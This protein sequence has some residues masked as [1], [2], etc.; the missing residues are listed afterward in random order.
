MSNALPTISAEEFRCICKELNTDVY[1]NKPQTFCEVAARMFTYYGEQLQ[2]PE[3]GAAFYDVIGSDLLLSEILS[4]RFE[5]VLESEQSL[6]DW[7]MKTVVQ[8]LK[9]RPA[10]KEDD[11]AKESISANAGEAEQHQATNDKPSAN[12]TADML[13]RAK[14]PTLA[15]VM[16]RQSAPPPKPKS[17]GGNPLDA[18]LGKREDQP[19]ATETQDP[20]KMRE[21]LKTLVNRTNAMRDQLLKTIFGQDHAVNAFVEG[22]FQA[23]LLAAADHSRR[24]PKATYLF[25]GP[26]GVGKTFLAEQSAG[27]LGLPFLRMDMSEYSDRNAS[28]EFIGSDDV[29]KGAKSGNVTSFVKENPQCVILF[30]EV[31]KA[32]ISIIHLFLQMLD[33]GILRDSKTDEEISFRDAILIFTTNAGKQLYES[34]AT[35][36][37]AG[38]SRKTVLN[39]LRKDIDP[40]TGNPFFPAAICSRF[41]TGNVVM[42]NHMESSYLLK[43]ISKEFKRQ[44]E[45]ISEAYDIGLC[46][47]DSVLTALLLA[48]GGNVDARTMSSRSA[49]FLQ[50]ELY[51]LFMLLC[52]R[53]RNYSLEQVKSIRFDMDLEGCDSEIEALFEPVEQS[54]VLLLSPD[55]ADV[56]NADDA[57]VELVRC[58][59]A[60]EAEAVLEKQ[61]I[62]FVVIDWNIESRANSEYLHIEDMDSQARSLFRYLKQTMPAMPVYVLENAECPLRYEERVSLTE[63]GVRC[64]F[65]MLPCDTVLEISEIAVALH[66]NEKVMKLASSN[67]IVTFE[68]AQSISKNGEEAIITLFDFSIRRSV[69]AEDTG[70]ILSDV[71]RPTQ[72]FAD[73]IGAED[74]KAELQYFV[75]YLKNPTKLAQMGMRQPRGVLLYGPPGTGKTLLA[76]AMAGE[77]DVTFINADGAQFLKRYVGEGPEAVKSLFAKARK[78]APTILFIDEIDAVATNR[79]SGNGRENTADILNA[80]LTEMDGFSNYKGK[81]V[82]VLAATNAALEPGKSKRTIDAALARRFDRKIYVERPGKQERILYLQR[83]NEA[84]NPLQ[85]SAAL[86]DNI[87][88]RSTGMSLAELEN[89]IELSYRNAV[90]AGSATVSDAIFEEAFESFHNG[91]EKAWNIETRERVARHEAGHA[92]LCWHNG[93]MP[94]YLTIVARGDHGGYMQQGDSEDKG[95][96]TVRDL[97]GLIRV[98]LGG[99]A[100]ELVYY[101]DEGYS[102]GASNDLEQ[103]TSYA[104]R[105]LCY[106]GMDP[107]FGLAVLSPEQLTGPQS[108]QLYDKINSVLV[109]ELENSRRIIQDEK[110]RFE[111][112]VSA[113]LERD[114][115][116]GAELSELLGAVPGSVVVAAN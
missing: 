48:E 110:E 51:E 70:Q 77:S 18:I 20:A 99:R 109:E 65:S 42:F 100:A 102:S 91:K 64:I 47:D 29:Y 83:L 1:A 38:I 36:N 8:M 74:A 81:P 56:L 90:R 40:T 93:E 19:A 75:D 111:R 3:K 6:N 11:T 88:V 37:L 97:R 106:Y 87:A 31:E 33:A 62:S 76:K 4:E 41:A 116:V 22:Y 67:Q 89:I 55:R 112:L 23:E 86:I 107:S 44:R 115:L 35:A 24:K 26:P 10:G 15:E 98:A 50:R 82:F 72:R 108:A 59:T 46:F 12:Q 21:A 14:L 39:A 71:S 73:V 9:E 60:K 58:T 49:T 2:I 13:S 114:Y 32:H 54:K 53:E 80:L 61:S 52:S 94:S 113:L 92:L 78:Y 68:T 16:K 34:A 7:M 28:V 17:S 63:D 79:D 69:D 101:G 25:A 105:M 30:D 103:A 43:I 5:T 104:R 84:D 45:I 66:R 27:I 85:L 96:Y 95:I 57:L